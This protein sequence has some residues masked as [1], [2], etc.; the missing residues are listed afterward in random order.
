MFV[1]NMK[2]HA[3]AV[4]TLQLGFC[5]RQEVVD[6]AFRFLLGQQNCHAVV[7]GD[8]G[9]GFPTV[10]AYIRDNALQDRVQTH[11]IQKQTFHILFKND[12]HKCQCTSINTDSP[13][14]LVHQVEISSADQHRPAEATTC[15]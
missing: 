4:D 6:A 12:K 1:K 3:A 15:C 5:Q 11:C 7:A 14:M 2:G 13:R 8:L 9:V 10:H